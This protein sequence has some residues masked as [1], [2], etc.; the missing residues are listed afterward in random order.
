MTSL[1]FDSSLA[2]S[3]D[4]QNLLFREARTANSFTNQ[5]VST[6]QIEAIY[7]LVKFGPTAMNNQPL[8]LLLVQSDEGRERLA[9]HMSEGNRA[10]TAIAPLV[11]VLAADTDF[12]DRLPEHFP[13]FPEARDMF[14]GKDDFRAGQA[15]F[16]AALQI[17][18]FIVG[19]RAAGLAAGPMGG[20]DKEGIDGEFF[21]GT[22]LKSQLVVNIGHPAEDAWLDRLPRLAVRDAVTVV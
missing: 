8:R 19:V 20:F 2:L 17:G 4:A 11:A 18:Y 10:K 1:M 6:D 14:V 13:H 16:N 9:P 5:H 22:A 12:H 7:E 21:A 3:E 15:E